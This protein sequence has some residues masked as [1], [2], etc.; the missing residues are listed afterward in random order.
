MSTFLA[1][2]TTGSSAHSSWYLPLLGAA[3][4][5]SLAALTYGI[6]A[7][8]SVTPWAVPPDTT[9]EGFR[10]GPLF[11][12]LATITDVTTGAIVAR[13]IADTAQAIRWVVGLA[14]LTPF[15][16]A[17]FFLALTAVEFVL[18]DGDM[19]RWALSA[20]GTLVISPIAVLPISLPASAVSVLL[21]RWL[22]RLPV[23]ISA[24]PVLILVAAGALVAVPAFVETLG[25]VGP[26]T[27]V[28]IPV[29]AIAPP[30][31]KGAAVASATEVGAELS[32]GSVELL[33]ARA[34]ELS[35][36]CDAQ[37]IDASDM[38]CQRQGPV[39]S[40]ALSVLRPDGSRGVVTVIID[41][42]DGAWITSIQ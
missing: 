40:V 7:A 36:L 1:P 2:V 25:Q 22:A 27:A 20:A 12:S 15:L 5:A 10:S 24:A 31:S 42:S 39:W 9:I 23:R 28:A 26:R 4:G 17:A 8:A 37:L 6:L 34:Y 16:G 21:L 3:L 14:L 13:R 11:A 33:S 18:T 19:G 35:D 29:L 30:I 41:G 38:A 32:A